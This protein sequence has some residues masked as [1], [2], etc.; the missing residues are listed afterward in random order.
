MNKPIRFPVQMG[1][2]SLFSAINIHKI[3]GR[4]TLNC[5]VLCHAYTGSVE[6]L[7]VL[8]WDIMGLHFKLFVLLFE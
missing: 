7:L 4:S 5:I 6:V 3:T 1:I 8:I 2:A